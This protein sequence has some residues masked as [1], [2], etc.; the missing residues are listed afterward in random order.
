MIDSTVRKSRPR[1]GRTTRLRRRTTRRTVRGMF[2]RHRTT[3]DRDLSAVAEAF[4]ERL[5]G[6]IV[7][8][9]PDAPRIDPRDLRRRL[10]GPTSPGLRKRLDRRLSPT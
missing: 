2:G 3:P 10:G 5:A 8:R 6:P 7:P 1:P 4:H 9:R